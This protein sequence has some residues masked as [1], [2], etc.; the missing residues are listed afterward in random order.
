MAQRR[1]Y[2]VREKPLNPKS[3]EIP[4][5]P[6]VVYLQERGWTPFLFDDEVKWIDPIRPYDVSFTETEAIDIQLRRDDVKDASRYGFYNKD[7]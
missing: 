7:R 5:S 4:S 1:R 6:R 2:S 3:G